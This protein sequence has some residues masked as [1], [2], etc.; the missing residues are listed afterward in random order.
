MGL[1]VDWVQQGAV[2]PVKNSGGMCAASY[3]VSSA[4]AL[5]SLRKILKGELKKLSEQEILDCSAK[6][7]NNGC[8]N[9]LPVNTYKYVVDH[10]ISDDSEYPYTGTVKACQKTFGTFKIS[11]HK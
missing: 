4:G 8:S 3:A 5:E 10:G 1:E 9:G 11:S 7:G 6:Y 2:L